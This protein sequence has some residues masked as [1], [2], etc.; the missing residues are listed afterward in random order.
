[1]TLGAPYSLDYR[2]AGASLMTRVPAPQ[3]VSI[4]SCAPPDIGAFPPMARFTRHAPSRDDRQLAIIRRRYQLLQHGDTTLAR[5][6]DSPLLR[7]SALSTAMPRS[8]VIVAQFTG[9]FM[10]DHVGAYRNI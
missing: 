6:G 2:H 4:D 5:R 7:L 9:Y 10:R 1:M 3:L 8:A